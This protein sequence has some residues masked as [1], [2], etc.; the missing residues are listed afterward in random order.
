MSLPEDKRSIAHSPMLASGSLGTPGA[1]TNI[2]SDPQSLNR[3]GCGDISPLQMPECLQDRGC[4]DNT[5]DRIE[6]K[7]GQRYLV[8][9]S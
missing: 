7:T 2:G 8:D 1:S 5:D 6:G 4:G 9:D 3:V